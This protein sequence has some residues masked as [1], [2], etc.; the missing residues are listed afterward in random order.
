MRYIVVTV[1]AAIVFLYLIR[2]IL[3][4]FAVSGIVAYICSPLLDRLAQ[5]TRLPRWLFAVAVFLVLL[6]IAA[7]IG[8]EIGQRLIADTSGTFSDLQGTI[9]NLLR[10]ATGG[11]P[12]HLFGQSMDAGDIVH[13]AFGR[14]HDWFNQSDRLAELTGYGLLTVIDVFLSVVLLI[15]L[16]ITGPSVARGLF[17]LVPPSRR[18]LAAQ[19]WARLDPVLK[20]YFIGV[21]ATVVYATAAAY[22]GLAL[23]L[24]LDHALLLSLMTGIAET[25]PFIGSTAVAIIAGLVALHTASGFMSIVAFALYATLLRL[26]IDQ[27]VAP[28]VLGR[29]ANLHP[30][31]IIFCFLAGA[32]TFGVTGVILSVPVALTIK[33]TLETLYGEDGRQAGD[34]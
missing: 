9:E 11:R 13:G 17:W 12:I 5:K 14:L 28:L 1:G 22:V 32:V 25:L 33:A 18:P 24:G 2:P 27:L 30:V 8:M 29:A 21:F 26:S 31:L 34:K 15:W 20:H 3:L 4:P 19:I 7:S 16:L 10:E 6:G 23:I